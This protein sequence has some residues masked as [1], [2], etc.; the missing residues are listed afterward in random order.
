MDTGK[1]SLLHG[2]YTAHLHSSSEDGRQ[3]SISPRS[4]KHWHRDRKASGLGCWLWLIEL[5]IPLVSILVELLPDAPI[6]CTAGQLF[7]K[8]TCL[9][10]Q[11]EARCVENTP[12]QCLRLPDDPTA[13]SNTTLQD[14]DRLLFWDRMRGRRTGGE[15][16]KREKNNSM[17][18]FLLKL[19]LPGN[20]EEINPR[21]LYESKSF[22][23]CFSLSIF[24]SLV[25]QLCNNSSVVVFNFPDSLIIFHVG[26]FS[27]QQKELSKPNFQKKRGRNLCTTTLKMP[28]DQCLAHSR[29]A[30]TQPN[31]RMN[32][33]IDDEWPD[34]WMR[35]WTDLKTPPI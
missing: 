26:A 2:I 1:H 18:F 7:L 12:S 25:Y 9:L 5:Y 16:A 28:N 23:A 4:P 30:T 11:R 17:C 32:E 24:N 31:R 21:Q 35:G 34:G 3:A 8:E 14:T 19:L 20:T 33:N 10:E 13:M 15:K 29:N 22:Q 6:T 27:I